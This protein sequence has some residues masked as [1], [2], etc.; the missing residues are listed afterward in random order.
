MEEKPA[1]DT[2]EMYATRHHRQQ[3]RK[4]NTRENESAIDN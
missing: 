3:P 1:L 2:C 4:K